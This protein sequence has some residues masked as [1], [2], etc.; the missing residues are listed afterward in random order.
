MLKS[1]AELLKGGLADGKR[2][3]QFNR[4]EL[5]HGISVEKE[6]TSSS[7]K[8]KEI[9]MDHLTEYP[10][11]YKALK[12][13]EDKLEKS[14]KKAGG[15]MSRLDWY[16]AKRA[17]EEKKDE[18]KKETK[19]EDKKESGSS[20]K[21]DSGSSSSSEKKQEGPPPEASQDPNAPA[22]PPEGGPA[23]APGMPPAGPVAAPPQMGAGMPP[24]AAAMPTPMSPVDVMGQGLQQTTQGVNQMIDAFYALQG[25]APSAAP[26]PGAAGAAAAMPGDPNGQGATPPPPQSPMD[27]AAAQAPQQ[28]VAGNVPGGYSCT[29]SSKGAQYYAFLRSRIDQSNAIVNGRQPGAK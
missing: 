23:A 17:A 2:P 8:A 20:E 4:V 11:Y 5:K 16:L 9:A 7:Q 19:K 18:K 10:N 22:A 6:H 27:P 29:D 12:Q 14:E 26:M 3:N 28:K 25:G 1:A 24:M 21:K 15:T 13:M